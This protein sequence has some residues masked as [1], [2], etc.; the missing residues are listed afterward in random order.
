VPGST[1]FVQTLSD[2]TLQS[3][4]SFRKQD[5]AE[6]PLVQGARRAANIA[7][8]LKTVDQT[9]GT[10]MAKKQA[11]GKPAD[12]GLT[13]IAK[14]ADS[15]EHLVLLRFEAR[16]RCRLVTAAEKLPNTIAELS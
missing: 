13:R 8:S 1:K 12:A 14:S 3:S 6:L 9:H 5:H 7:S 2:D 15:Q 11:L 16:G 10:V 4:L